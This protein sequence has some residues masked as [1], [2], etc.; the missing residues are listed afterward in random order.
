MKI[1][2]KIS[3]PWICS[4][5]A[6]FYL[7]L[8]L[9][10][11]NQ[12]VET[13]TLVLKN[14]KDSPNYPVSKFQNTKKNEIIKE[15]RTLNTESSIE[16]IQPL[17][18]S[19]PPNL[20]RIMEGGDMIERMGAYLDAL[21]AMDKGNVYE[22][23]NAFEALPKGYGRHLEMKL[24]MRSWAEIDPEAALA[25][26][27][28]SLD[29]KSE[30]RFGISEVLAGWANRDPEGA[31]SWAKANNSSDKPED[32]PLLLGVVKGLAENNIDAAN[33]I[34]RDLPPGSAKW[35]AST[36][37][38]Q[39]YSDIGMREAIEWA[40]Q[41]PKDDPRMRST[42]LGQLGA[43]L[44]RQDIEATAKWVE[45]LQDDKASFTVMNNL[46]TQWVTKDASSAAQWVSKIPEEEKKFEGMKQL[47]S[48]W[49]LSDPISTAEWLNTF[50]PS[51]KMDPVVNEFV[52]RIC[53]RDPEGAAGWALSI[54]DPTIKQKAVNK[55]IGAWTRI[56]P[57]K[58]K[59]WKTA[60]TP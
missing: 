11:E 26:A 33:K 42:I 2:F 35:Q 46:L 18:F 5:A 14:E 32:N 41:F 54:T 57:E 44:A 13:N 27:D 56:D 53:T 51:P 55:A 47:T 38:A 3:L 25:Y 43:K 12:T 7:G 6:V 1:F 19:L 15:A 31:I 28:S 50:P 4:L 30:R 37:L 17:E 24:L 21:R 39:K 36:F 10:K 49:S 58:A 40:D 16:Q 23:V 22:V 60:N 34:F 59:A 20:K 8:N 52:N 29:A 48:R 9:G 45:S